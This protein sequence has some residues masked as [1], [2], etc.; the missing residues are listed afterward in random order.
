MTFI[1]I[2]SLSMTQK[3]LHYDNAPQMVQNIRL[4]I[5]NG[6]HVVVLTTNGKDWICVLEEPAKNE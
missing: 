2:W 1:S 6:Y 5:Q 3:V 4:E